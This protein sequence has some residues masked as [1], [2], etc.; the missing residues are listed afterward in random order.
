MSDP[1]SFFNSQVNKYKELRSIG[2]CFYLQNSGFGGRL[3]FDCEFDLP[4]E[5][6]QFMKKN[7]QPPF[8]FAAKN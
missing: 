3:K 1:N 6:Q 8:R 4:V 7:H 5:N 2:I